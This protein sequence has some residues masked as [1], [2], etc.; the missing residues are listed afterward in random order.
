MAFAIGDWINYGEKRYGD[1]YAD[2]LRRTG[3]AYD[4]LGKYAH[5]S[6]ASS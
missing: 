1:K 2:A 3:P 4:T 6:S 5:A